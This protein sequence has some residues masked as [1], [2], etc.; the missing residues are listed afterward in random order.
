M[1]SDPIGIRLVLLALVVMPTTELVL[2]FDVDGHLVNPTTPDLIMPTLPLSLFFSLKSLSASCPS[3][4]Y[5]LQQSE[6]CND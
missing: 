5:L 4:S 2:V 1:L 3:I 6:T